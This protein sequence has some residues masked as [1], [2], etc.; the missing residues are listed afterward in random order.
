MPGGPD[1]LHEVT[2]DG[3]RL[4]VIRDNDRV[5]SITRGGYNW[6]NR[7]PWNVGAARKMRQKRFVLDGEAVVL[8]VDGISDFNAMH[9]RKHDHEVQF[10]AFDILAEGARQF[11]R[12]AGVA[13]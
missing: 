9:S 6:A 1:Y 4:L 13:H 3:Y 12:Q 5:R 11:C 2:Y 10:C 7:Y 8:G